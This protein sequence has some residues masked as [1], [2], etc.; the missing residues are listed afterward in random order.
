MHTHQHSTPNAKSIVLP[1]FASI[2]TF[3][4]KICAHIVSAERGLF[5]KVIVENSL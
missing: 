5:M 2:D 3:F 1:T 4:E